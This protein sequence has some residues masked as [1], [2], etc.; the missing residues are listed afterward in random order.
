MG[1]VRTTINVD[2]IVIRKAK[3]YNINISAFLEIRL[4][5]YLALIERDESY[6]TSY[7][8]NQ[9]SRINNSQDIPVNSKS[10]NTIFNND[11]N[12]RARGVAWHPSTLGW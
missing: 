2:G 9:K 8:D 4:R 3:E 12:S 6:I 1:K 7:Y 5:E 11:I 10:N